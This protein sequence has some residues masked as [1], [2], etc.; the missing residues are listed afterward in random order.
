MDPRKQSS[1]EYKHHVKIPK[2]SDIRK[3]DI[4]EKMGKMMLCKLISDIVTF[5]PG[6]PQLRKRSPL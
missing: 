5:D 6:M 2:M 1:R 3:V 4:A